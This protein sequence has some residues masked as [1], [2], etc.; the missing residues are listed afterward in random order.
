MK[1]LTSF[2]V[3]AAMAL[4][5]TACGNTSTG[6]AEETVLELKREYPHIRLILV[7]PCVLPN[8]RR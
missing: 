1:K 4:T 3:P 5:V 2:M 6:E 7:L 8:S